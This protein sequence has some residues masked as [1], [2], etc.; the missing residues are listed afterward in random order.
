MKGTGEQIA[1]CK[2]RRG[3]AEVPKIARLQQEIYVPCMAFFNYANPWPETT[4]WPLRP[5]VSAGRR[6]AAVCRVE[7]GRADSGSRKFR[8]ATCF[9]CALRPAAVS[10]SRRS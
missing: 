6:D 10:L 3:G 9:I 5:L 4:P 1:A 8:G 2:E 7:C